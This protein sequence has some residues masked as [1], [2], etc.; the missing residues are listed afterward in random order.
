MT[1]QE[2]I[3]LAAYVGIYILIWIG[4]IIYTKKML[5]VKL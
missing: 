2:K 4:I 3:I 1:P 5:N